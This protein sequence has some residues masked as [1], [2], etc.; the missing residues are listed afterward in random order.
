MVLKVLNIEG[1]LQMEYQQKQSNR[2]HKPSRT[3]KKKFK[4]PNNLGSLLLTFSKWVHTEIY[5]KVA[6]FTRI[7]F[8]SFLSLFDT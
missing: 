2:L 6:I 1:L 4:K 3:I 8:F 7:Q 5:T